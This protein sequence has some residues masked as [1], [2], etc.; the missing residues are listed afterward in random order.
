[1][2]KLKF[3]YRASAVCRKGYPNIQQTFISWK[4]KTLTSVLSVS[5]AD[6]PFSNDKRLTLQMSS[7]LKATFILG[8]GSAISLLGSL[9]AN[10]AYAVWVGPE[11]IGLLSLFQNLLSLISIVAGLGLSSG[12][13]RLAAPEI[14]AN[15]TVRVLALRRAGWQLFYFFVGGVALG[16]LLL[17]QFVAQF[18]LAGSPVW[19]VVW[20]VLALF[21]S[22]GAGVRI[23]LLNAYHRVGILARITAIS[24]VTG[25]G[26]GILVVW[27]WRTQG[28]PLVVFG[29]PLAQFVLATFYSRRLNLPTTQVDPREVKK[30]R[31]ALLRFGLPYTGSQLVSTA[32]QLGLPFLVLY[33]LGQENLGYYRAAVMFSV[34]YV[35]F[36]LNALGQDFY[37]RL[38]ALKDQ[39]QAFRQAIDAQQRFLLLLGTPL[40]ALSVA[41]APRILQVIFSSEFLP[42][43]DILHWQLLGDLP[44]FVSWTLGYAVLAGLPTR[45]YLMT[46]TVGGLALLA[47]SWLGMWQFGLEGLGIGFLLAYVL[48]LV[49]LTY[50]FL[51]KKLWSPLWSNV[52]LLVVGCAVAI[53][54]RFLPEPWGLVLASAWTMVCAILLG[55]QV[56]QKKFRAASNV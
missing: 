42:A 50:L 14:T 12:L 15:N 9:L 34:G 54:V 4:S 31:D 5:S 6:K 45:S 18:L 8:S 30:A 38:S 22:M 32:V 1:M 46:E 43:L 35:G 40:I 24:S 20:I 16:T 56:L 37:P 3:K 39:P 51:S 53:V 33:Q 17:R 19:T 23:G 52:L 41:L 27:L 49:F 21:L 29:V 26:W 48:Y 7:L 10:K 11:G 44:K 13:V 36:L 2:G 47:L 55:R 25:A 28:L